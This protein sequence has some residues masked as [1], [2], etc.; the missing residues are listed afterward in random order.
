[1]KLE[2]LKEAVKSALEIMDELE[3]V[4]IRH[5]EGRLSNFKTDAQNFNN[6][7]SYELKEFITF[8]KVED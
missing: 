7:Y 1:M 8:G 3:S 5:N 6:K 4:T 2:Q